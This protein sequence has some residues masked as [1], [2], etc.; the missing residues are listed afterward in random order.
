MKMMKRVIT[1][2]G[3]FA[4]GISLAG[5]DDKDSKKTKKA[6]TESS[7]KVAA[8]VPAALKGKLIE[9]KDGK[10]QEAEIATGVDYYVLYHSA[11][12]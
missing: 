8:K 12:W 7:E 1:T 3:I 2:L 9:L 6:E 5:A 4:V 10:I 11:S